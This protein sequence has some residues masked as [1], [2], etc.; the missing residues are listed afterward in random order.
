[1]SKN[2]VRPIPPVQPREVKV[3]RKPIK[4]AI[5]WFIFILIFVLVGVGVWIA[6]S[7]NQAIKKITADS[8]NKSSIFSFLGDHSS[9][10][11]KGQSDGRTNILLLGMGGKNH[12]GGTL[13][14]TIIVTSIDY[15]DKRLGTIS[16]PRDLWVPIPGFG[17]EK[18]NA[19]Y[20]EGEKNK[21]LSGSG[22]Q[23]SS[24]TVENVLGIPIHYYIS[25]DFEGFKK[26]VDSVG[27]IDVYVE[28]DIYDPYYPADNMIDYSPFKIS[29]GEHHMD[30]ALALKYVRSRKTTSDFDRSRRQQQVMAAVKEKILTLNVLANPKKV[31]DLIN[32]LGD[33][34]RTNM[35]IDEI[36]ALWNVS[37]NI[38]TTNIASKVFDTAENGPLTASQ[39]SRGYYIYPRKGIDKFIDLQTA[40][41]NLFNDGEAVEEASSV[42]VE[43]LNGTSR[44]GVASTVSQYLSSYGYKIIRIGDARSKM[45]KTI[46]YDYSN[47]KYQKAA[48][49]IANQLKA[50]IDT[51]NTA[52]SG[53]DIQVI[54]GEDYF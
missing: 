9:S 26:I 51:K 11:V 12:P 18:I 32:I 48:E 21:N 38:N 6:L 43:V 27:G 42:R 40:A 47:G 52:L 30:G 23:L 41:R 44:N 29:A 8:T 1:M 46:V 3:Y 13:S 34:I 15:E 33:H 31:T 16:L 20:A 17:H 54:V 39:D 4:K 5:K 10:A 36:Y 53:V 22:G 28:K 7:A 50:S 14:D 19:A 37:K 24:K 2:K 49:D 35:Q 45:A 25:L